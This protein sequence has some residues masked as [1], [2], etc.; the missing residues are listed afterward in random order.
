MVEKF[1]L[2]CEECGATTEVIFE[3]NSSDSPP[4]DKIVE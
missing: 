3:K 4:S 1:F 2:Y